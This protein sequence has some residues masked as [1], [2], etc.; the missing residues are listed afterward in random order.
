MGQ[1]QR[2]QDGRWHQHHRFGFG[3][4]RCPNHQIGPFAGFNVKLTAILLILLFTWV[5]SKGI[6]TGAGIST[7]VLVLVFTGVLTIVVFGLSSSHSDMHSV[8]EMK[9]TTSAP[10]TFS[11]VFTA[12]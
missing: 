4:H 12:M 6:K 11:A 10:V 7:I 5:N 3:F 9:N 2:H 1:Q 8:F